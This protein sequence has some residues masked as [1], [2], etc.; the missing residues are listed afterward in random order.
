[1]CP[2]LTAVTPL[3]VEQKNCLSITPKVP[4]KFRRAATAGGFTVE[5]VDTVQNA[6]SIWPNEPNVGTGQW[7]QI[8]NSNLRI[9]QMLRCAL[10]M[11]HTRFKYKAEQT[12][13]HMDHI[14]VDS[15][16][17]TAIK[18]SFDPRGLS[19]FSTNH[20]CTF[21]QWIQ[22]TEHV[23]SHISLNMQN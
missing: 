13:H 9:W 23:K 8:G 3:T 12:F 11:F 10:W 1:M 2:P 6:S 18:C 7:Q 17:K 22:D 21:W 5:R 16:H 19:V 15:R 20:Q 14:L 4:V